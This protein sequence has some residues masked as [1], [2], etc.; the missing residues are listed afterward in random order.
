MLEIGSDGQFVAT[1]CPTSSNLSCRMDSRTHISTS[2]SSVL[3]TRR[4]SRKID[5]LARNAHSLLGS[6]QKLDGPARM[7]LCVRWSN[8]TYSPGDN[9]TSSLMRM[10]ADARLF[11]ASNQRKLPSGFFFR[12][13]KGECMDTSCV[14]WCYKAN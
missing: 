1:S 9:A 7:T 2:S 14:A 6:T 3:A 4:G 10:L 11:T 8:T 13:S 5:E 12:M